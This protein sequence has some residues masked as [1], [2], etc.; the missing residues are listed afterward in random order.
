MNSYLG[1]GGSVSYPFAGENTPLLAR[2]RKYL[3]SSG[4]F[5]IVY[6]MVE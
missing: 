6:D 5:S 2:W 3:G 4:T 1:G